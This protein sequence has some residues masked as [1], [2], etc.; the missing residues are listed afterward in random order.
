MPRFFPDAAAENIVIG[1][2]ASESRSAWSVSITDRVASLHAADM[3]GSQYFPLYVYGDEAEEPE[4][5]EAQQSLNLSEEPKVAAPKRRD[6]ITDEGLRYFQ[7]AY[8][9][10]THHEGRRFLLRLWPAALARLPRALRR[11]PGQ[12]TAAHPV[13]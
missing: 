4:E 9:G 5:S 8:P 3:V 6:G 1:V 13:R 10:E 2:S 11:Q 12:G 7:A